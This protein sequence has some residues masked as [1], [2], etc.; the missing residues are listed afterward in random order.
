MLEHNVQDPSKGLTGL[1]ESVFHHGCRGWN[2]LE[3]RHYVGQDA[4]LACTMRFA[5][6]GHCS[7]ERRG[8]GRSSKRVS[9]AGV[10]LDICLDANIGVLVS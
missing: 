6:Q 4:K 7:D 10:V 8:M 9:L 1:L 5:G 2:S 3:V